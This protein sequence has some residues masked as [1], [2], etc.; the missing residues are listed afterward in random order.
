MLEWRRREKMRSRQKIFEAV[1][2]AMPFSGSAPD[3]DKRLAEGLEEAVTRFEGGLDGS[4]LELAKYG[5]LI[6]LLSGEDSTLVN[7]RSEILEIID[8]AFWHGTKG[9]KEI[10]KFGVL[11]GLQSGLQFGIGQYVLRNFPQYR[12]LGKVL[13]A[14]GIAEAGGV[15]GGGIAYSRRG[16]RKRE[17]IDEI[18]DEMEEKAREL[19]R[20]RDWL[21]SDREFPLGE[22]TILLSQKYAEAESEEGEN[23]IIPMATAYDAETGEPVAAALL[24]HIGERVYLHWFG[25]D[26]R[27]RDAGVEDAIVRD[28]LDRS[29]D[30]DEHLAV[31]APGFEKARWEE[32]GFLH[33]TR[34]AAEEMG[35]Q[36]KEDEFA[37][38]PAYRYCALFIQDRP[39]LS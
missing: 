2:A 25:T 39:A 27:W 17:R 33:V 1:E 7:D 28:C 20:E 4:D 22:K 32:M 14:L 3:S 31:L 5:T 29:L 8:Y 19:D 38:D 24:V 34:E 15:I 10:R 37:S 6:D 30:P 21:F 18:I 13:R 23:D 16:K 12:T 26:K 36:Y 35:I 11:L 9:K